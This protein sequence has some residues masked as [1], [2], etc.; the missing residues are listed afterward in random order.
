MH[1]IGTQRQVLDVGY[2]IIATVAK[3][4]RLGPAIQNVWTGCVSL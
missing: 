1:P 4:R 3:A 2:Q